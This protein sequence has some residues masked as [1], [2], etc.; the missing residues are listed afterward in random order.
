MIE[1]VNFGVDSGEPVVTLTLDAVESEVLPPNED[2][3]EGED[4][5]WLEEV[6]QVESDE[7]VLSLDAIGREMTT[8]VERVDVSKS[9][10]SSQVGQYNGLFIWS[11]SASQSSP[12]LFRP[13]DGTM[14]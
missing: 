12:E 5:L 9:L 14:L 3:G 7:A 2:L 13:S 8:V 11:E 6:A 10:E 4:N 1:N